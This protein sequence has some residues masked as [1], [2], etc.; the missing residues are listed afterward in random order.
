MSDYRKTW[1]KP[2]VTCAVL[3]TI[4]WLGHLGIKHVIRGMQPPH[5]HPTNPV[6]TTGQ[7]FCHL[8][9]REYQECY[10]LLIGKRKTAAAI[11][12]QSRQEG[13]FPHFDRIRSYLC[14]HAGENFTEMMQVS[15][16][17]RQATFANDIVLTVTLETSQD[18]DKK[19]HYGIREINEFPIDIAPRIGVEKYYR[20]LDLA[21]DSAGDSTGN[22]EIDDVSEI[23][24]ER[25]DESKQQRQQRMI[26]AFKLARQ[27]D[28]RH[29]LLEKWIIGE[30]RYEPITQKFL[31]ELARD[32]NQPT[33]LRK[34]AQRTLY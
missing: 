32:E 18:Y 23:I 20:N 6:D 28:T 4:I 14:E 19:N 27:L 31:A 8:Y 21:I 1:G 13:Y 5:P 29:S 7:F 16:D 3:A 9:D 22:Q 15:P 11:K 34:L 17:G 30:F 12:Q 26:K 25:P 10:R 2:L 33:Q 24:R